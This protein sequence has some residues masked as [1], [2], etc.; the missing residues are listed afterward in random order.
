M[1]RSLFK[2][3]NKDAVPKKFHLKRGDTV[4]VI[5][6]KDKGKTGTIKRV[7][8]AQGRVTVEGLNLMKKSMRPNPMTGDRGGIVEVEAPLHVSNVMLYDS[9]KESVTRVKREVITGKDGK[10]KRVRA[11]R[12]SG[13]HIDA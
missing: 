8:R 7:L 4:M 12:K 9:K 6:G 1:A 2:K 13:E 3:Y 11:A 5:A 10:V